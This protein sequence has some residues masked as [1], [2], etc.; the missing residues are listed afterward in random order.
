M[1]IHSLR[2]RVTC[3]YVGL[4]AVALLVFGAC[5]YFGFERYLETSLEQSL[6][7]EARGIAQAFVAE[8]DNKGTAWLSEE[9]SEAYPP[10]S[11]EHYIRIS[12]LAPGDVHRVLYQSGDGRHLF[13][14]SR[15][16]PPSASLDKPQLRIESEGHEQKIAVYSLPYTSI[17][18]TRYL[19]ET[20]APHG[21]IDQLLRSLLT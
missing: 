8:V 9:L 2:A 17:A 3:W 6:A 13:M 11:G 5:L 10:D 19:I 16:L 7:G 4:L 18:G 14:E 21:P 20:A 12:H 1:S 15:G